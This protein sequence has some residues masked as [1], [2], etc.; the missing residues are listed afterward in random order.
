MH[1]DPSV[2]TEPATFYLREIRSGS[3]EEIKGMII[4]YK[5]FL[6]YIMNKLGMKIVSDEMCV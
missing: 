1:E 6:I 2:L 3:R 5:G 4:F